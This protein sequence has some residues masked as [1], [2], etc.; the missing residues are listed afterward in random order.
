MDKKT[1]QILIYCIFGFFII[2]GF[3]SLA[4]YGFLKKNE[5]QP[6]AGSPGSGGKAPQVTVVVWGTL[7]GDKA[8]AFFRSLG[9]SPGIYGS[10]QYVEKQPETIEDAYARAILY[11][12]QLPDLF[13]LE[14]SVVADFEPHLQHIPYEYYP[15]IQYDQSFVPA[16]GVFKQPIAPVTVRFRCWRILWCCII[17]K[18]YGCEAI[19]RVCR[20]NGLTL[21][22]ISIKILFRNIPIP[23]LRLYRLA[24][25]KIMPTHR[26]SS[27]HYC[28][29]RDERIM[30]ALLYEIFFRFIPALLIRVLRCT[31]GV[32]Y[33]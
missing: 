9:S 13:L 20:T 15:L 23:I 16:A 21:P 14:S 5:Q 32:R 1:F 12:E 10:V 29:R 19:Y 31:H 17:T 22:P 7:D 6:A 27:Q 24:R 11:D 8:R 28:S 3:G 18:I 2:V 25:M 26:M 30:P 4:L 33:F